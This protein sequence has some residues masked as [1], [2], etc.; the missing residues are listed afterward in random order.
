MYAPLL[1]ENR[2]GTFDLVRLGYICIVD[3]H[4]RVLWSLGDPEDFV[5]YRSASKP[6]QSLPVFE[7]GLDKQYGFTDEESVVLS[8]SHDGM[9]CHVAAVESILKKSGLSEDMMCMKPTIPG[10]EKSNEDRIRA[11]LPPRKVYHNCSGKHCALMLTQRAL[12]GE[13]RDYWK[14][15]TPVHA[16]VEQTIK[17]VS[18]TDTVKIGVDGCGV[19]VFAVPVRSIAAAYKNLAC[20]DTIRDESLRRAAADNV[21]RIGRYPYMIR[22]A[23]ILC[24]VMNEDPNIIAK[25]GANGVYGFGLKKQRLGVSLK[26]VDGT[27]SAWPFLIMEILRALGALTPEHEAR[28]EKLHPKYFVNDNDL[29]VGEREALFHISL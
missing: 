2:G 16:R 27:E 12:G 4:S 10:D 26:L 19:P 17:T 28:L 25:G 15:G 11:G 18:E 3:E 23:G 9:P 8:A 21:R 7:L 29:V 24:S 6:I 14:T 22:G 13:V 1:N 20:I 5:F